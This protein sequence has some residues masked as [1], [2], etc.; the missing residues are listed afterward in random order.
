VPS[1]EKAEIEFDKYRQTQAVLPQ[2]IDQHFEQ[3]LDEL[4]RIE[5]KK[6]ALPKPKKK[7]TKKKPKRPGDHS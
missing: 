7:P 4:K 1:V 5:Q 2:P 6:K 3:T